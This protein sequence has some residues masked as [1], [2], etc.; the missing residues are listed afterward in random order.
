M[1]FVQANSC[2]VLLSMLTVGDV[3]SHVAT[4]DSTALLGAMRT[5]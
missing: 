4:H 3:F 5:E 1:Q 2:H